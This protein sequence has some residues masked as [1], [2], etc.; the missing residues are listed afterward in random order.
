MGNR[1]TSVLHARNRNNCSSL[2]NYLFRKYVRDNHLCDQCGVIEDT[3]HY[4]FHCIKYVDERQVFHDTV[5]VFHPLTI[6]LI[7]FGNEN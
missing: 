4:F 6:H 7:L 2:N 5:K 1:Y 3:I